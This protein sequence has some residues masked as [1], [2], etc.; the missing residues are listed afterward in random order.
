MPA[1]FLDTLIC[2]GACCAALR[3]KGWGSLLSWSLNGFIAPACVVRF[4]PIS[5]AWDD[6]TSV[7]ALRICVVSLWKEAYRRKIRHIV[8]N[9]AFRNGAF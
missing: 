8:A 9:L 6:E 1:T 7:M 2:I 5:R 3:S 4:A